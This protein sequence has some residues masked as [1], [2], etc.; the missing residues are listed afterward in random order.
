MEDEE[1][2]ILRAEMLKYIQQAEFYKTKPK[3]INLKI[4]QLEKS[5]CDFEQ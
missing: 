1:I 2:L 3:Y 4:K 5:A